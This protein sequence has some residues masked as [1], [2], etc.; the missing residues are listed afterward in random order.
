MTPQVISWDDVEQGCQMKVCM[1]SVNLSARPLTLIDWKDMVTYHFCK[2]ES[3]SH[4]SCTVTLA[5]HELIPEQT[6]SCN[7]LF[8]GLLLAKRL[9][10]RECEHTRKQDRS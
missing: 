6:F 10:R 2:F 1:F 7:A 5:L 8:A 4:Y 9:A 3:Q